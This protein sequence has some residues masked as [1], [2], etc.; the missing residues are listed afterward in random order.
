MLSNVLSRSVI[1][2]NVDIPNSMV[3]LS[4]LLIS[5]SNYH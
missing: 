2:P 5:I 4:P 1:S 3:I